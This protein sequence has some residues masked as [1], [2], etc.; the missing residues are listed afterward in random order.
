MKWPTVIIICASLTAAVACDKRAENTAYDGSALEQ[1]YQA[2][3]SRANDGETGAMMRVGRYHDSGLSAND[4]CS[5]MLETLCRLGPVSRWLAG[6]VVSPDRIKAYK[7]YSLAGMR[8]HRNALAAKQSLI[9][10][11]NSS[12]IEEGDRL[13]AK[14]LKSRA[15]TTGQRAHG[16]GS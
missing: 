11:M 15:K 14:W 4:R 6:T 9:A 2:D 5:G 1:L 12:E 7:W 16:S 8:E 10:E 3:L 13:I